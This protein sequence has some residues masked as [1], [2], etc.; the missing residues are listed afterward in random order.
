V[1]A[2][3]KKIDAVSS[4]I[5][6][7]L[8]VSE[9]A[10]Q[11]VSDMLTSFQS[12]PVGEDITNSF[13]AVLDGLQA[14][15]DAGSL[16]RKGL[17]KL[18][19]NVVVAMS[20][21]KTIG[22]LSSIADIREKLSNVG[23]SISNKLETIAKT[24]ACA[25]CAPALREVAQSGVHSEDEQG[26]GKSSAAINLEATFQRVID[27]GSKVFAGIK[28]AARKAGVK[29][30]DLG[31]LDTLSE[32]FKKKVFEKIKEGSPSAD[33]SDND[34]NV[35]TSKCKVAKA[36]QQGLQEMNST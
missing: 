3:N 29:E 26:A 5:N 6:D 22:D 35:G 33:V 4:S 12:L 13:Q 24:F 30:S 31:P 2:M 19:D 17:T 11:N 25:S 21:Y 7:A 28:S 1:T 34:Q 18:K 20:G 23:I 10:G 36:F 9:N 15:K 32:S 27:Q 14:S 16:A 8:T